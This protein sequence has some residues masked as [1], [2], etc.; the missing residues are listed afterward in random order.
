MME[1]DQLRA[2]LQR[3]DKE[4]QISD[5]RLRDLARQIKVDTRNKEAKIAL[6]V[7]ELN[8]AKLELARVCAE[9]Q[10]Y[11]DTFLFVSRKPLSELIPVKRAQSLLDQRT[12]SVELVRQQLAATASR[13]GELRTVQKVHQKLQSEKQHYQAQLNKAVTSS[14]VDGTVLTNEPQKRVGDWVDAGEDVVELA[15]SEEWHVIVALTE[16]QMPKVRV[17]QRARVYFTAFPHSEYKTFAGSVTEVSAQPAIATSYPV[18]III[19]DPVLTRGQR[20]YELL[21]GMTAEVRIIVLSGRIIE[22]VWDKFMREFA[23]PAVER[24]HEAA[25]FV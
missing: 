25:A 6:A 24:V 17:G 16:Q 11:S 3:I 14:P 22:I 1:D 15:I 19:D 10:L 18:K 13:L 7:S 9:Q 2:D 12:A 8:R 4:I 5:S 21:E 23:H 20:R